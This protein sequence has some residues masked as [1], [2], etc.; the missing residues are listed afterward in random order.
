[1]AELSVQIGANI[2]DL[3]NKLSRAIRSLDQLKLEQKSLTATFKA[4]AISADKYYDSFAK[5][6]IKIDKASN[7]IRGFKSQIS[8]ANV[9]MNALGKSTANALPAV[10]EFSRV[11]QDAPFGIMGVGNNIQ[12]LTSNFGNLSKSAGGAGNALKLM[13][14]SLTGPAG[15]LLAVSAVTTILTVYGDEIGNIIKGNSELEAS[16]KAVTKALNDFYGGTAT[17]INSYVSILED[18]NTKEED[19]IRITDELIK[20]VPSLTKADF[21]Y[22][23]NLDIVKAKIGNYV[24]AQ[25]SRIEADTLVEENS[26][27]LAKKARIT[28]IQSIQEQEKRVAAFRKFLEG[29]GERVQKTSLTATYAAG[30]RIQDVDK[31]ASEITEDFNKFANKLESELGPVQERINELYGTTFS[32][33]LDKAVKETPLKNS[34]VINQIKRDFVGIKNEI[35]AQSANLLETDTSISSPAF[36]LPP[37]ANEEFL[38]SLQSALTQADILTNAISNSFNALGQQ[39]SNSLETGVAVVDAFV[40]S[41][42]QS[43]TQMLAQMVTQAITQ[44][45]V[46]NALATASGIAAQ[47]QGVQ[48]ATQAAAALGPFGAIALPGLLASTQGLITGA[49]AIAKVPKFATGGFSGDNNLA[50][51]NKDE[52]V[53]RPFEQSMLLNALRGSGISNNNMR[54]DS[55]F[56]IVGEVVL[57]GQNQVIQMKRANKKMSRYYNS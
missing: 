28:Q 14:G 48:I 16:Q 33:G 2:V 54:S 51:L 11:I 56:G 22:G 40:G 42:V 27:K 43:L 55:N 41:I 32:G 26:E 20:L 49:L 39:I 13:V 29:E 37:V 17:K 15:I 31:T 30:G 45:I 1:M 18:A 8:G 47:A 36:T 57:R 19:R 5:N 4:G 53:L 9:P 6:A 10:Q 50:F 21:K 7:N 44:A 38:N 34:E 52:L 23:N 46:G 25:A 3:Q 24:L 12:Q 35:Q